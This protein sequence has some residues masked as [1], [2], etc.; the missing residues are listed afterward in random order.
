MNKELIIPIIL[1][2]IGIIGIN[3]LYI[4]YLTKHNKIR[5]L[6]IIRAIF[7]IIPIIVT[8]LIIVGYPIYDYLQGTWGTGFIDFGIF[9]GTIIFLYL[10]VNGGWL[11]YLL[12]FLNIVFITIRLV[13]L[14][15][16]PEL[17]METI[18]V[19]TTKIISKVEDKTN[20]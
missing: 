11:F 3:Y 20:D 5:T 8:L 16:S 10:F 15:P 6:K 4:D 19:P 1:S 13:K 2:I 17:D 7:I 9:N 12:C 18:I 14:S